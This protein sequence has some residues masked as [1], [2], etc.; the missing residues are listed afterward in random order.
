VVKA[1]GK[2]V[3]LGESPGRDAMK[4]VIQGFGNV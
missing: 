4:F 2:P 1:T 3:D